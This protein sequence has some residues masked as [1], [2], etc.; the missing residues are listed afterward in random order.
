MP[1]NRDRMTPQQKQ[2]D[3]I[4]RGNYTPHRDGMTKR[5]ALAA[6]QISGLRHA[7]TYLTGYAR[8]NYEEL[9]ATTELRTAA[10]AVEAAIGKL[11][12][13]EEEG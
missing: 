2:W 10:A 3:T 7:L 6:G 5:Q 8:R 12:K 11:E 4:N 9:T 13:I 1:R